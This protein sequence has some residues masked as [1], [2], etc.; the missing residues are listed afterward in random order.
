MK[1]STAALLTLVLGAALMLPAAASAASAA[2]PTVGEIQSSVS[3]RTQPSTSSDVTRYL[4]QGEQVV[5]LEEVNAY[6]YKAQDVNGAIGYISSNDK[7]V[8]IV[9]KGGDSGT[10]AKTGTIV[11]S[12]SFRTGPSTDAS[13]IRYLAKGEKV[14]ITGQPNSYWYAVTAADGKQGYVSSDDQYIQVSGG[15]SAPVESPSSANAT[16]IASVSLRTGP[17]T[18]ASRIRYLAKGEKVTITG[19]PN[20][21]WY[22]VTAADGTKGYVSSDDKYIAV[23]GSLPGNNPSDGNPNNGGGSGNHDA[24]V[25][26]VIAAGMKYLGTPYEFGSDR[27]TTKTF[28]CSDFVRQAFREG[29]NL[30]LPVDSRKQ[31]DYVRGLGHVVT[32]WHQLKRGDIMFFMAYKGTKASAYAGVDKSDETITHCGIYLGN[33]QILHTYSIESGGV[34]TSVI[35]GTHWEYRFLFGGSVV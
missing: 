12:V 4:K 27:D 1:K 17:S 15:G 30:L 13:R 6:W 31:G 2:S 28:D 23:T 21:Y 29:A 26:R 22:A 34:R 32:D 10:A 8:E 3:F 20:G 14:T 7:Y 33:G 18:D 9:A 16:I 5:I 35:S 25:E 24:L 19:Q 11:A